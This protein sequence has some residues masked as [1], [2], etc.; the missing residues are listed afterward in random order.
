MKADCLEDK[1][2]GWEWV[3]SWKRGIPKEHHETFR[4]DEFGRYLVGDDG[5]INVH[6]SN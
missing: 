6:V 3:Y 4:G 1:G 2:V 5:F